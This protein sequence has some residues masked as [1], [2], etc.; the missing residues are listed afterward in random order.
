MAT[1][2]NHLEFDAVTTLDDYVAMYL[3]ALRRPRRLRDLLVLAIAAFVW[4][5]ATFMVQNLFNSID[6]LAALSDPEALQ[7]YVDTQ[8]WSDLVSTAR[9][10]GAWTGGILLF[11]VLVLLPVQA[12]AYAKRILRERPDVDTKDRKLTQR[13]HCRLDEDGY[14]WSVPDTRT[15]FAWANFTHLVETRRHLFMMISPS[16]GV[17]FPKA[18]MDRALV[19]G[20][21]AF[22]G[23]HIGRAR[24]GG[25]IEGDSRAD[26]S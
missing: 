19:D 7:A 11:I 21:R 5:T 26:P 24:A 17:V 8:G 9:Q 23:R 15:R 22:A 4:F 14:S 10:V 6:D 3:Y 20:V 18:T 16:S 25:P 12:R 1:G 13:N 2:S